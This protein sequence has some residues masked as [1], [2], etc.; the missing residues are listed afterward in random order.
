[1][2]L[3]STAIIALCV[4]YQGK[5]NEACNK[6]LDAGT[7]QAGIRQNVDMVENKANE[8]ANQ[9]AEVVIGKQGMGAIGSGVYVYKVVKDKSISFKV[10]TLGL[11]NSLT[12]HLTLNSLDLLAEWNF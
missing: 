4:N 1:M 11:C 2:P 9:K 3:M 5:Y 6:A 12:N 7:R 8:I 10:P